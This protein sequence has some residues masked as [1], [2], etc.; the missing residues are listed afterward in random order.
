MSDT[1]EPGRTLALV[2]PDIIPEAG[3]TIRCL[4]EGDGQGSLFNPIERR[5]FFC[6]GPLPHTPKEQRWCNDI[7]DEI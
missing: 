3:P 6:S 1:D 4:V 7:Q 5:C 2:E